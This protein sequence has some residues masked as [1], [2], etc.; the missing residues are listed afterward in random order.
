MNKQIILIL[1]FFISQF[2]LQ[3]QQRGRAGGG[4][5][6]PSL[7]LV[8]KV[9][10][11]GS[12][13]GLEFA[14]ISVYNKQDS[15]LITGGLTGTDGIF[16]LDVKPRPMYAV[17]E[18]ISY[19]SFTKDIVFDKDAIRSGD[20][21]IDMGTISMVINSTQL[22][23]VEITAEKSEVQFSLDKRIFNVGKD[24]ANQGGS[25]EDIL[26]NVPSV[27]VDIEGTVS[28][29]G[30]EGVRI[31][32]DGRP[33]TLVGGSTGSGLKNIPANLIDQ[34]EV[35][36]NPSARYEAAGMAGI[37][38]IVL[39]KNNNSGFNGSFDASVGYPAQQGIGANIN[40]RK[41]KLNWFANY[42]IR[43]RNGPRDGFVYQERTIGD[44]V[45]VLDSDRTGNRGGF[46][47]S[48]RLGADYFLTDKDQ[49][50]G[51]F[52]YRIS[53]DNNLATIS[54]DSLSRRV[55]S[56]DTQFLSNT[57]RT[58]DE[59]EDEASLEYNIN[60]RKEFSS[61]DHTLN[62]MIQYE[63]ELETESSLFDEQFTPAGEGTS[64]SLV[65]RSNNEESY[66]NWLFQVDFSRPLSK[67]HKY[68]IGYRT[69]LRNISNDYI[70]EELNDDDIYEVLLFNG[71]LFD[72]NFRYDENIHALYA[73]Y[74][75]KYG[76]FSYQ[77]GLRAE[78]S[79]VTTIET[80]QD[81]V[82]ARDYLDLFPSLHLNYQIND[83]RAFQI[84]YS[85]RIDRPRFWFLNPFF[86]LSDRINTF[87]GNPD[88]DPEYTDSYELGTIRYWDNFSLNTSLF[89]RHTEDNIQRFLVVNDNG[90]TTRRPENIGTADDYGLDMN[91][92]YSGLKWLRLDA[93]GNFFRA[94][95]KGSFEEFSF[96]VDNFT[97]FGRLTAR[98]TFFDSDLQIRSNY[99][100]S[101]VTAQGSS[102]G[103]G[104]V[105]LGWSKDFM[106][107][108]L[109]VTL[110]VR[111]LFNSNRYNSI[112]EFEDFFQESQFQRRARSTNLA[113]SYRINQKKK[114]QRGG[115]GGGNYD[116]GGEF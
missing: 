8:G 15:T 109:T 100:G 20:R 93:N 18:F 27:T 114:R 45:E 96:D 115:G 12:N 113:V 44:F 19:N 21:K 99:R 7:K 10:D 82:N 78:Y 37:I 94:T 3:A 80:N 52:T 1:L 110:S 34:I 31:L 106:N 36:T 90:T 58:D 101:R 89:Y 67:D 48:I 69:S 75:N 46:S 57:F 53:D 49:L 26:D 79:D 9:I 59:N 35:I 6:A 105:D 84:S 23:E 14:T 28:L 40:Y 112:V 54:Y 43:N 13:L 30:S 47:N 104:S 107:D 72:N 65:Q 60:Y 66:A 41:N 71:Q 64:P 51:S 22:D 108:N 74:G 33:S 56:F 38:N 42:S 11:Q 25:A 29:R 17:F 5:A 77:A 39:K 55:G 116:G 61:R 102:Q 16:E 111:D 32:V 97:W 88:L 73:T 76:K 85:R 103:Q 98:I 92:S 86:T 87:S 2:T 95:S 24:L 50:T 91:V 83:A 81:K 70:V 4:G 63:D 68:E 62:A